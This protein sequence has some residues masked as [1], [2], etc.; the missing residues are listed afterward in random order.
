MGDAGCKG[1]CSKAHICKK[2]F[3]Y[4]GETEQHPACQ[5]DSDRVFDRGAG[6]E[7]A[8]K[9]IMISPSLRAILFLI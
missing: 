8:S 4:F 2:C 3:D 1:N 5:C 6:L 9:V 7:H